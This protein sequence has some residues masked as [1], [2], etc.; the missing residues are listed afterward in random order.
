MIKNVCTFICQ[1]TVRTPIFAE[2][3][4]TYTPS[5]AAS[6][7]TPNVTRLGAEAVIAS[8]STH[9]GDELFQRLPKLL[10]SFSEPLQTTLSNSISKFD[11]NQA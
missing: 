7:T 6:E 11:Q 3:K 1:D 5:S 10:V 2:N 4:A 8:L 9:F